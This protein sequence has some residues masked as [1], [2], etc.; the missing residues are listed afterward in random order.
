MTALKKRKRA[1][2]HHHKGLL[3]IAGYAFLKALLFFIVGIGAIHFLY[4]DIGDELLEWVHELRVDPTS[5]VVN[6]LLEHA[7]TITHTQIRNF[8]IAVF[9]YTALNLT[10]AIGL[11]FEKVWA[12]YMTLIITG[13]FLPLE[14][15]E[16]FHK[17]T[18]FRAGL[19]VA[20][21]LVFIYLLAIVTMRNRYRE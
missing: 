13:S 11:Y 10:E 6:T 18:I 15:Y 19:L 17:Q 20:N 9:V 16:L 5:H 1:A 7:D 4:K 8:S 14:L 21:L 3:F 12:E 2:L